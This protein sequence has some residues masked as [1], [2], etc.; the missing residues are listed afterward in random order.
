MI[1]GEDVTPQLEGNIDVISISLN[2][3][4][5]EK[6]SEICHPE[7]GEDAFFSILEFTRKCKS[8]IPRVIVT[9]VDIPGIDIAKCKRLAEELGVE[10]RLRSL[11]KR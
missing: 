9:V 5:A 6:Y 7:Y 8:H 3:E 1:Y 4:N 2:A 11:D 10:F